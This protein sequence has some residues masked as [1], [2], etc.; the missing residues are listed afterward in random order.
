MKTAKFILTFVATAAMIF[1]A[2]GKDEETPTTVT[3]S[4]TTS[5]DPEL[6]HNELIIG[7]QHY[8]MQPTLSITNEGF[9]LF[10][11][12]DH[13][14]LF[15]IIADVPSTMLG[16]TIDLAQASDTNYF[17]IN[18]QS[19]DLSFSLQQGD[20]PINEIN[21]EEVAVVFTRGSMQ[22]TREDNIVI[23]RVS[24]TLSNGTYVGFMMAVNEAD[25]EA[26]DNQIIFDGQV[27]DASQLMVKHHSTANMP[28]EF[29]IIGDGEGAIAVNVEVEEAA[30][31]T[32]IDLAASN[33]PHR[34]RVTIHL[35]DQDTTAMQTNFYSGTFTGDIHG[36]YWDIAAQAETDLNEPIFSSGTLY[37]S[38]DDYAI[39]FSLTGTIKCGHSVSA[40]MRV[41]KTEITED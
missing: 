36:S 23:L 17:Y 13:H 34:Y 19:T 16:Q 1:A 28:Y 29:Y 6:T 31:E 24:G 37:V 22:F 15:N 3:P 5:S 8:M 7:S 21:G 40:Q 20:Q 2:C 38:E 14:G 26:M 33:Y 12:N 27:F 30:M 41:D 4:G 25:I 39:G 11:A 35:W 10:D 9:Y 18:L 32:N